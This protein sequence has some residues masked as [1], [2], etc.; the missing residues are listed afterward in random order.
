MEKV[1]SGCNR[2]VK[3]LATRNPPLCTT[4]YNKIHK[5]PQK[6]CSGCGRMKKL[7]K[8]NPPLCNNCCYHSLPITQ[9]I[10]C[11]NVAK[12]YR[13]DDDKNPLCEKCGYK[14]KKIICHICN[15]E[16][17]IHSNIEGNP[18]CKS[19]YDKNYRP[20]I[21]CSICGD[22]GVSKCYNKD[23]T[24]F[25]CESCYERPKDICS[26][27]HELKPRH[28]IQEGKSIC[29]ECYKRPLRKCSQCDEMKPIKKNI[30]NM[31]FCSACYQ[32]YR[33]KNDEQYATI[34]RLRSR[35]QCAFV[36][37]SSKGKTKKADEYGID[38]QAICEYLGPC[39][40]DRKDWHI[41]HII[42]LHLFDFDDTKDIKKAFA[43]E[44]HQWLPAK[45]NMKKGGSINKELINGI[46]K[47]C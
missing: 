13:Y 28:S 44:N 9:C 32:S 6:Q 33:Y 4:C 20:I 12:V 35:L 29:L 25:I 34:K 5:Q 46:N 11:G 40:G 1:C 2:I 23:K 24:G 41:D 21:K 8:S 7:Q 26:I 22:E 16:K 31:P 36:Q 27:C 18:I 45:E 38:Y 14:K 47:N 15:K 43:P 30:D 39:P 17:E 37:F 42:P 19:C 3:N 10:S